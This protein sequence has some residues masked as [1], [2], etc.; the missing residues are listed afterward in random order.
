MDDDFN[1]YNEVGT[2]VLRVEL[3]SVMFV[4]K[5]FR[6]LSINPG[7]AACESAF[8]EFIDQ[9]RNQFVNGPLV[10]GSGLKFRDKN[11]GKLRVSLI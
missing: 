1:T 10:Y 6:D 8:A 7:H 2:F 4:K 11:P 9:F 5:R 3:K